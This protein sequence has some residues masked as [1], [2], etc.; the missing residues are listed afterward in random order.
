MTKY[1]VQFAT[2]ALMEVDVEIENGENM[3]SSDL[4][5]AVYDEMMLEK[6]NWSLI[7]VSEDDIQIDDWSEVK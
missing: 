5:Q 2:D 1:N 7:E 3:D 4:E 6:H